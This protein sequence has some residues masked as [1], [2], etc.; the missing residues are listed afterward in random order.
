MARGRNAVST[1]Y[2]EP[3]L[4]PST[5]IPVDRAVAKSP[6]DFCNQLV[7]YLRDYPRD[8]FIR[9]ARQMPVASFVAL[10]SRRRC[11]VLGERIAVARSLSVIDRRTQSTR[12]NDLRIIFFSTLQFL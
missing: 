9:D 6:N 7:L 3:S 4:S 8:I 1:L 10:L 2:R 5:F 12:D 11:F